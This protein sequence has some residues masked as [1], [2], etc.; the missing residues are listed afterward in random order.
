[1]DAVRATEPV[2][3]QMS[4]RARRSPLIPLPPGFFSRERTNTYLGGRSFPRV[5][6]LD[7][8]RSGIWGLGLRGGCFWV[9]LWQW[10]ASL[11]L[12]GRAKAPVPTQ[13]KKPHEQKPTPAN[14]LGKDLGSTGQLLPRRL[15]EPC[16]Q[17]S[18]TRC[19]STPTP[20]LRRCRCRRR[21]K[22][23]GCHRHA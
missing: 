3:R 14:P 4:F 11:R 23:D 18:S 7:S 20:G 8:L 9:E 17:S 6:H 12:A 10:L 19:G 2:C 16:R 21:H 1:M 5:Y 15:S 22:D 13:A